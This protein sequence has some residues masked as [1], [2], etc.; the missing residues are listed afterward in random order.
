[1]NAADELIYC[2]L[3]DP[4]ILDSLTVPEWDRLLRRARR[5]GV[6]SRLAVLA[7]AKLTDNGLPERVRDHLLS[8]GLVAAH[9]ERTIRWEVGR[10]R[11]ALRPTGQRFVLLK[12]AAYVI[13]G[14]PAGAGRLA[15]DVD[16]LVPKAKLDVVENALIGAGWEA[17]KLDPYDQRYYRRWMHE[18]PPL[19]HATRKNV[20]DV[21]H[22]ILPE[23]ARLRPDGSKLLASAVRIDEEISVLAP[24]DMVLH[25]AT[26]L[27]A[28]GDLAGGLRE[29]IDL[30]ALLRHFGSTERE[31]WERLV[32]R[33]E[34]LH[35]QRP[36][37]YGLRVCGRLLRT[38]IPPGVVEA[39]KIGQPMWPA[40]AV[41][42]ALADRALLPD[43]EGN[44]WGTGAA[45][46][47][48]YLRSHWL[49]MPPWQLAQH[50]TRK[51]YRR[52]FGEAG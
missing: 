7:Q 47:F 13:A 24:E 18:L 27:F 33:S 41:M 45:L 28:D 51:T 11:R 10:I 36:L 22:T 40:T 16:I 30:D 15:S 4:G 19:R 20:I 39:A 37:F 43:T 46:W 32:P 2:S 38:P 50:L 44:A 9:H 3:R 29:V 34:E 14:L 5:A 23:T 26:H 52:W 21:H 12:G 25:T 48:L 6:L 31:F 17:M 49:R 35:L 8:A 42:D 1:M